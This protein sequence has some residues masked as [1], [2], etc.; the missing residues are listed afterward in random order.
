M[1]LDCLEFFPKEYYLLPLL[2]LFSHLFK[3]AWMCGYL[4]YSLWYDTRLSLVILLIML[5]QLWPLG[6]VSGW[7]P[8]PFDISLFFV[9][10]ILL[11][12]LKLEDILGL[13]CIFFLLFLEIAI[14]PRGSKFVLLDNDS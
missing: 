14:S 11:Y 10:L 3:F 13:S 8:Y 7:F 6:A 12:F 9:S 5:V 4:F 2:I 1:D